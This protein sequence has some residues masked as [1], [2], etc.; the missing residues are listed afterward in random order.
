MTS[1]ENPQK[2]TRRRF[3]Q[4]AGGTTFLAL[5]ASENGGFSLPTTNAKNANSQPIFSA[6]PY[7]QPGD[8]SRLI[9]G[10]GSLVVAWQTDDVAARY[11]VVFGADESYGRAA[12]IIRAPRT[13]GDRGA[14]GLN[15]HATLGG[16]KLQT[17]YVYRVKCNGQI[18]MKGFFT[19]RK[20]RGSG[21]R[22]V[23]F[24]DNSFGGTSDHRIAYQA[25]RARPDFVM[26]TGD[27]VYDAGLNSEYARHFFPVYNSPKIGPEVGAPL[28]R[29]VPFYTVIANHDIPHRDANGR[30]IVDFDKDPDA[31]AYFTAMHLPQNG[32]QFLAHPTRTQGKSHKTEFLNCAGNRFP[33]MANY[34]FD[35]GDAHFLCL[36]SNV[37]VDPTNAALQRFIEH[38]LTSTN[39]IWKFVVWHHPSF[40]VGDEH[41]VQQHM[42]ALSPLLERCRVDFVLH[43]HEHNYQR[44]RPLHF[45]PTNLEKARLVGE[46]DRRTPGHFRVDR[47]FDGRR[48]TRANGIIYIVTGAGGNN[49]YD[50]EINDNPRNWKRADDG[51][52]E[53]VARAVSDRHSLSVFEMKGR[54]LIMKQV[55]E[56]GKTIDQIVVTKA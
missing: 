34:S 17:R 35:Y 30:P 42:R 24:G 43:G 33:R 3:L 36:D 47:A 10:K 37:Y 28:L 6:L 8:N 44:T 39:A 48:V 18:V 22:F 40:N 52:V 2:I 23:A 32:P 13:V 5:V 45:A 7:I 15:Y 4:I 26:N 53:Y 49:L 27:N 31:L 51:N 11:E 46:R 56:W 38:D 41:Y 19:T 25:Y 16:L 50:P 1:P 55:D 29:S 21:T 14:K 9:E 20:K 12:T 54:K